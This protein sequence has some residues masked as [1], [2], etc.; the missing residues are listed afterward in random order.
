MAQESLGEQFKVAVSAGDGLLHI[1]TDELQDAIKSLSLCSQKHGW[2]MRVWDAVAGSV[3]HSVPAEGPARITRAAQQSPADNLNSM[4]PPPS[5]VEMITFLEEEPRVIIDS[6]GAG[7]MQ[8]TI[9]VIQNGHLIF[10]GQREAM[11][12]LLQHV[13]SDRVQ[14]HKKYP[15]M[16][17][18]LQNAGIE[19]ESAM[20]RIVVLL[21]PPGEELPPEILPLFRRIVHE[22]PSIQEIGEILDDVLHGIVGGEPKESEKLS[23]VERDKICRFALGLTRLQAEG[24]FAA[25]LVL[26]ERIDPE[27][28][29]TQKSAILNDEKL[30]TLYQGRERFSDVAGLSGAKNFLLKVLT[31]N[32][33]NRDDPDVRAKGVVF[34]GMPGTG[35]SLVAKATGNELGLP[36]LMVHPGNWMGSLVGDTEAKTRKAFQIIRAHAPCIAIV[37]EVEKVMP[38]SRG[39]GQDGGVGARM[40]GSFLSAMNDITEPVFWAF[41]ANDV[42]SMHEA[43]FRAERVDVVF[44]VRLPDADQRA[45]IW[46]MYLGKF[47]PEFINGKKFPQHL[48]LDL[49]KLLDGYKASKNPKV[50]EWGVKFATALLC[51]ATAER[52]TWMEAI[53]ASHPTLAEAITAKTFDDAN[54]TPAEIKSCCRLSRLQDSTISDTR[55]MIR[56]VATSAG[57]AANALEKWA[58]TSAIDAETGKIYTGESAAPVTATAAPATIGKTRR[59]VHRTT[60]G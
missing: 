5:L 6:S 26:H 13:I 54:W 27:F 37:D 53:T 24:V 10:A 4:G 8:P 51:Y 48:E 39:S 58:T 32:E 18:V 3:S 12:T 44:Y 1:H 35:K 43:F 20:A 9:L 57:K 33:F 50:A 29:W 42:N 36:T 31:P 2:H 14:N 23:E 40:E 49:S 25:S 21:S 30:V 46:N 19:G 7:T 22:L 11:S 41:T 47:F 59:R 17:E 45:V 60:T 28:V 16:K 55:F 15:E 52:E 56:P 38:R 34:V